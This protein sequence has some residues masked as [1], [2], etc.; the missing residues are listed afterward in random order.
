MRRII[1]ILVSLSLFLL[2][3]CQAGLKQKT[4][5]NNTIKDEIVLG[6]NFELS[7]SA[8]AY[9]N[10]ELNGV[11]LAVKEINQ[12]GG[13]DGKKIKLVYK[14]NKT[15]NAESSSVALNLIVNSKIAAMIGPATSGAIQ[16]VTPV[17]NCLGVPT[18]TPSGTADALTV[19]KDGKVQPYIFRSCF[20]DS[21]QGK[22]LA[23]YATNNLHAKKVVLLKDAST[24]Y[25]QG[26]SDAFIG[27]YK[28][29]IVQKLNYT[30]GDKDF[31]AQLT[32]I[33]NQN[34]DALVIPG[35]YTEAGLII[36]QA[37]ELGIK[38]PILGGDGFSD[39]NLTQTAGKKNIRD[40][41][42]SD[43]FSLNAPATNKVKPFAASYKK[44]YDQEV[45][46][47]AA[48]AYDSVYMIKQVVEDTHAK[49]SVDVANGL[50]KLKSFKG[51]T[52]MMT[53]K[54]HNPEKSAVVIGL[55]K[56]KETSATVVK[57]R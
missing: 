34:F 23:I 45:S 15:E 21:F 19:Q 46:A 38:Q 2:T 48:L 16:A 47:F 32:K 18:I 49:T 54:D 10:V 39:E 9:G 43:H 57:I 28:G 55:T 22:I 33:K 37:R 42:Y 31:Q 6:A 50:A 44:E 26:V 8:A 53:M 5:S 24:D 35:Y 3:A 1:Y 4:T 51:V 56:G 41:Y 20:Q 12:A 29:E 13:I 11:R 17:V 14:D 30:S 7:G 40:V 52:G 36:R 27:E 25:S